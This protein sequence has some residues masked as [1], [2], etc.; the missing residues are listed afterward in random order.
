[1]LG[2]PDWA[3]MGSGSRPLRHE[4]GRFF[5]PQ[6]PLPPPTFPDPPEPSQVDISPLP[7]VEGKPVQLTCVSSANPPPTN[8]SWFHNERTLPV[9]T[10]DFPISKVGLNHAGTYSCLA[11]NSLGRGKVG[12]EADLD[13][14]CECS[15]GF[16]KEKQQRRKG[17][18]RQRVVRKQSGL[19]S[20]LL[21]CMF[22]SCSL[23]FSQLWPRAWLMVWVR[24]IFVE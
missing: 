4:P 19:R 20:Q 18:Q 8:F 2:G 13:V 10:Q 23:L 5:S 22:Y 15:P 6:T 1:M 16:Q 3:L 7:A 17:S 14:Q 21:E 12:R 11:E 24:L 9:T